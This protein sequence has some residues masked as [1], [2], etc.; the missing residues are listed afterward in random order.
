MSHQYTN[1]SIRATAATVLANRGVELND[2]IKIT[3]HKDT[4]SLLPYTEKVSDAK[5]RRMS[6]ILHEF[7]TTGSSKPDKDNETAV[8]SIVVTG[9]QNHEKPAETVVSL[10]QQQL[11][12]AT[13]NGMFMGATINGS[14]NFHFGK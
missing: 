12:H 1:H 10:Y 5:R 14:I 2:I 3:G 4:R 11:S 9:A 8:S 13:T 6:S 7:S